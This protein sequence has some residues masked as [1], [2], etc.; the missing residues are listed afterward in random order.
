LIRICDFGTSVGNGPPCA[1]G[2]G[3][4]FLH[5][6]HARHHLAENRVTKKLAGTQKVGA[7]C[8]FI[9]FA[10]V[11]E[12]RYRI[13]GRDLD[14]VQKCVVLDIDEKLRGCR[15][16]VIG[17]CH[18]QR[19]H[20]VAWSAFGQRFPSFMRYRCPGWLLHKLAVKT[21]ALH[22]EVG[23]HA[24][25]NSTVV[26]LVFDI[27]QKIFHRLGCLVGVNLHHEIARCGGET[28]LRCRLGQGRSYC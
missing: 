9:D 15:L 21:A 18:G 27:L 10:L 19:T 22:H 5:H 26:M 28:D 3:L 25:K 23:D 16:W 17:S 2:R 14:R 6:I 12:A 1:S 7:W 8:V 11:L 20:H 4:D 24:V 13:A